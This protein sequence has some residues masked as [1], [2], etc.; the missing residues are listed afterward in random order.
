[1]KQEINV[2]SETILTIMTTIWGKIAAFLPNLAAAIVL[3][4]AGYFIAK[5]VGFILSKILTK[6]GFVTLSDKVG[7]SDSLSRAGIKQTSA[8]IIGKVGFWIIML[9]FL[10]SAT[11]SLGLPNISATIHEFILY[12]P[13]V[14]AAAI[15][16]IIGLFLANFVRDLVRSSAEGIGIVYAKQLSTAAYSVL[17]IIVLSLAIN[18]LNIDTLLLNLIFSIMIGALGIAVALSLGLGTRDLSTSIMAG[19]YARDL[20]KAGDHIKVADIE[21]EIEQVGAVKTTIKCKGGARVSMANTTLITSTV[22]VK[23]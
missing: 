7:V 17:F 19:V 16:F 9:V 3:L 10:V 8:E 11:E 12:L 14:I 23:S 6:I 13:Q 22:S 5:S 2:W 21:G 15:L 1:M 20:F 4:I 18:Q